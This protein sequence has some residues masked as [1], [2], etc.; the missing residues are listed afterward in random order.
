MDQANDEAAA[1]GAGRVA[2]LF[3]TSLVGGL[4]AVFGVV[5]LES[6]HPVHGASAEAR[7]LR[8]RCLELGVTPEELARR[9]GSR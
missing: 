7:A 4:V 5:E 1:D 6:A 2:S 9:E 3:V 8:A